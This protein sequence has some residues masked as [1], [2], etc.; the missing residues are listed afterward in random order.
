MSFVSDFFSSFPSF[1]SVPL[2]AAG[3]FWESLTVGVGVL[4]GL[5]WGR[6]TGWGCGGLVTPGLLALHASSPHRVAAALVVGVFLALPLGFLTRSFGLYGRERVGA[7][8]LLALCLRLVLAPV[9]PLSVWTGWVIPGL[10][11]ADVQRQG[12][13]MTLCGALSCGVATNFAVGLVRALAG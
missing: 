2:A 11:A 7:A 13:L 12:G 6:R 4:L 5:F 9:V 3:G 10:I 1:P 8:M